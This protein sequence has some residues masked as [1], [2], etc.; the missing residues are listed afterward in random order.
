MLLMASPSVS[1]IIKKAP[2]TGL[3]SRAGC[4]VLLL[5]RTTAHWE[6]RRT[7]KRIK[8]PGSIGIDHIHNNS[9]MAISSVMQIRRS[10]VFF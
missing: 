3:R 8:P 5:E 9:T 7:V 2:A 6:A 1:A 4:G 10:H